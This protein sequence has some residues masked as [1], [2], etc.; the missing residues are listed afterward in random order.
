MDAS[1]CV[2]CGIVPCP[3][4]SS[5]KVDE[6]TSSYY[7]PWIGFKKVPVG[8]VSKKK[9]K[10]MIHLQGKIVQDSFIC[11]CIIYWTVQYK[12]PYQLKNMI[13]TARGRGR[14]NR[15]NNEIFIPIMA[16]CVD[17]WPNDHCP[18]TV[19]LV[20]ICTH[21]KLLGASS[22]PTVVQLPWHCTAWYVKSS[23]IHSA[24]PNWTY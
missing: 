15:V 5:E 11:Q 1:G 3:L 10:I 9:K 21:H 17:L 19:F 12:E 18:T 4:R 8:L 6:G 14:V 20:D 22:P 24:F 16:L 13:Q 7:F 2:H 23:F